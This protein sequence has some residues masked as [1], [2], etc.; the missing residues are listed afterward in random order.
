M[1]MLSLVRPLA[2]TIPWMLNLA[3]WM[4]ARSLQVPDPVVHDTGAFMF[5]R[6]QAVENRIGMA[7]CPTRLARRLRSLFESPVQ[8]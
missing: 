3:I 1:L 7:L 4:L 2:L 6:V 8:R 5:A